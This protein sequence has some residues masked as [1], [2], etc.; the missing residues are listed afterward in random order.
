[1]ISRI[2][3]M[4]I[5]VLTIINC[6]VIK[7]NKTII[8]SINIHNDILNNNISQLIYKGD[9]IIRGKFQL[10]NDSLFLEPML[11]KEKSYCETNPVL[12]AI[13][14]NYISHYNLTQCDN[15]SYYINTVLVEYVDNNSTFFKHSLIGND[16]FIDGRGDVREARNFQFD[17]GVLTLISIDRINEKL[18]LKYNY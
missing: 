11:L 16:N 2:I 18:L 12:F 1:M 13:I 15:D 4:C 10:K 3:L 6:S 17:D 14:D 7:P 8:A 9:T 5:C